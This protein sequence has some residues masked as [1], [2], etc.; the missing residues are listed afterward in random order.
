MT[1]LPFKPHHEFL[2]DNYRLS[3][4]RLLALGHGLNKDGQL[5]E[6]YHQIFKD[7]EKNQIIQRVLPGDAHYLSY[8]AVVRRYSLRRLYLQGRH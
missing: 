8:R 6:N 4:N 1:K 2:P 5:L 7:Y 3:K